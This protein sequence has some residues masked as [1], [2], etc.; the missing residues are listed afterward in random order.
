M[1]E[2]VD[3]DSVWL[4]ITPV[5]FYEATSGRLSAKFATAP[6]RGRG[7]ITHVSRVTCHVSVTCNVQLFTRGDKLLCPQLVFT[8]PADQTLIAASI[9]ALRWSAGCWVS[10]GCRVW[11]CGVFAVLQL[12]LAAQR[13]RDGDTLNCPVS[14]VNLFA[15][16]WCGRFVV[17]WLLMERN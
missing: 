5:K 9:V 7:I 15:G 17:S 2:T 12:L 10:A 16:K 8:N 14:E 6:A 3:V 4:I 1:W 11:R 13:V